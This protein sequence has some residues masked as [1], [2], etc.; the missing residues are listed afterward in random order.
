[1]SNLQGEGKIEWCDRTINILH[2]CTRISAWTCP[3]CGQT[4]GGPAPSPAPGWRL[5]DRGFE[6]DCPVKGRIIAENHPS[7]CEPST[8]PD[9]PRLATPRAVERGWMR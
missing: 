2:G 7:A 1:M 4:P 8:G 6:H 9:A 3:H 5:L